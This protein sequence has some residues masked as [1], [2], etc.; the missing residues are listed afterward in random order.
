LLYLEK[1]QETK[2]DKNLNYLYLIKLDTINNQFDNVEM[3]PVLFEDYSDTHFESCN[4]KD[5]IYLKTFTAV[6][7]FGIQ[8]RYALENI[9]NIENAVKRKREI[10]NMTVHSDN[11]KIINQKLKYFYFHISCIACIGNIDKYSSKIYKSNKIMLIKNNITL[12]EKEIDN[13]IFD[14]IVEKLW[15]P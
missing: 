11:N 7:Q 14:L 12:I 8:N 13:D 4:K 2:I 9:K 6:D 5:T 3:I 15:R 1:C 10:L